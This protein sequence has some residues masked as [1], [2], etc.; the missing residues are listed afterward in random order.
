MAEPESGDVSPRDGQKATETM[1]VETGNAVEATEGSPVTPRR[2]SRLN[3]VEVEDEQM[4]DLDSC[5]SEVTDTEDDDEVADEDNTEEPELETASEPIPEPATIPGALPPEPKAPTPEDP[6]SEKL[7]RICFGGTA[8]EPENGRLF[9]PCKCKGSMRYVHIGCLNEWRKQAA[10]QES[11]YRCDQ[12][13]YKY[14]FRRTWWAGMVM[15]E[16]WSTSN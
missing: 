12:C 5:G 7:C 14:S 4:P 13:H 6:D 1:K 3:K 10:K 9:S 11:F 16:G 15:N 8:E 2:S